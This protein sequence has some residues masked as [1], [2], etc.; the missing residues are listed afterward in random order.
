MRQD[1]KIWHE[2]EQ[3]YMHGEIMTATRSLEPVDT[4]CKGNIFYQPIYYV[5]Y[6]L[7]QMGAFHFYRMMDEDPKTAWEEYYSFAV[8]AEAAAILK[9]WSTQESEIRSARKQSGESWNFYSQN[10][11]NK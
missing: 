5:D 6:A 2:L 9:P 3:T 8:R 4:G 10:F 7:A 11:S 1:E